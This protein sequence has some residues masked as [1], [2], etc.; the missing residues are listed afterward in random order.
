MQVSRQF[1][2]SAWWT[3]GSKHVTAKKIAAIRNCSIAKVADSVRLGTWEAPFFV[4]YGPAWRTVRDLHSSLAHWMEGCDDFINRICVEWNLPYLPAKSTQSF[5]P[6]L[7]TRLPAA[8]TFCPDLP[9]HPLDSKWQSKGPRLWL[10]VDCRS[11]A[12]LLSGRAALDTDEHRRIFIRIARM[13]LHLHGQGYRPLND[14][15]DFVVR[16]PREFNTV[17]DHALTRLWTSTA[18][19]GV[20]E[21]QVQCGKPSGPE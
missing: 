1:R 20:G 13:I 2:D 17:A 11:I 3:L 12:E 6:L 9:P 5:D 16:S 14:K 8:S 7:S 19:R 10:Q 21:T 18:S 15:E 4:V